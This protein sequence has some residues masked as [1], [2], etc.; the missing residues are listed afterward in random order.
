MSLI[1]E[2]GTGDPTAEAYAT[3]AYADA[4]H[5]SMGNVAWAAL[6]QTT[7]EVNMRKAAQYMC[8]YYR[9]DWQGYRAHADQA[10]DWPRWNVM[11][12][13]LGVHNVILPT[14]IPIQVQQANCELALLALSGP[15]NPNRKQQVLSK[16]V[17]PIKITYDN[18]SPQATLYTAVDD[19]LSPFMGAGSGGINHKLVR[20]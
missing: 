10:L 9:M 18:G 3:T 20:M 16:Q 17:G 19:M 13:D 2:T 11:V 15:L 1:V 7:K 14:V 6:D 4:Y 5:I 8:Q 12:A